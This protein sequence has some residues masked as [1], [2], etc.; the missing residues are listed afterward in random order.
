MNESTVSQFELSFQS[1]DNG[2]CFAFPCDSNGAID[3]DGLDH[4][5]RND[6]LYA[7]AMVG[8]DLRSPAVRPLRLQ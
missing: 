8:R 2:Q 3:M 1:F 6:Y 7:R 4:R 5:V